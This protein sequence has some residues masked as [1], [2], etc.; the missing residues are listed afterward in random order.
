MMKSTMQ[1]VSAALLCTVAAGG[2][3]AVQ[4]NGRDPGERQASSTIVAD[5]AEGDEIIVTYRTLRYSDGPIQNMKDDP[6]ARQAWARFLPQL[7][8]AQI[9]TDVDLKW[10]TYTLPAGTHGLSLG[11]NDEGG[12]NLYLLDGERMRGRIPLEAVESPIE[13]GYLTMNLIAAG[14]N[15]F[16]LMLGYGPMASV[17][18]FDAATAE[19]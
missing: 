14:P 5:E 11:M 18:K 16:Q 9:Q 3:F 1:V 6:E 13:F 10:R 19:N 2:L 8:Q 17:V 12:W 7:L 4:D 15:S